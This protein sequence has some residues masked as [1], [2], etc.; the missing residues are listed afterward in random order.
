MRVIFQ[1]QDI[2]ELDENFAVVIHSNRRFGT[3][4][5]RFEYLIDQ[6]DAIDNHI[7]QVKITIKDPRSDEAYSV[8]STG[9]EMTAAQAVMDLLTANAKKKDNIRG[10]KKRVIK[11]R[12]SDASKRFNNEAVSLVRLGHMEAAEEILPKSSEFVLTPAAEIRAKRQGRSATVTTSLTRKESYLGKLPSPAKAAVDLISKSGIDPSQAVEMKIQSDETAILQGVISDAL[13]KKDEN[14]N[15]LA[16]RKE[17]VTQKKAQTVDDRDDDDVLP[18]L[19]RIPNRVLRIRERIRIPGRRLRKLTE[20]QVIFDVLDLEGAVVQRVAMMVKHQDL[21][22][23]YFLPRAAPS[24]SGYASSP[25]KN[26]LSIRQKD[27]LSRAVRLYRREI[28]SI[29]PLINEKYTLVTE[30]PLRRREGEIRYIDYTQNINPLIYRV[31]PVNFRG[32]ASPAMSSIV[33]Y[34]KN[35]VTQLP[36]VDKRNKFCVIH[37]RMGSNSVVVSVEVIPENAEFVLF[38]RRDLTAHQK[39]FEILKPRND[40]YYRVGEQIEIIDTHQLKKYHTYEYALRL[41]YDD[42]K[43]IL[44]SDRTIV[45]YVPVVRTVDFKLS[46]PKVRRGRTNPNVIFDITVDD[47]ASK[48]ETDLL[49]DSLEAD[50]VDGLAGS[51]ELEMFSDGAKDSVTFQVERFNLTTG[52]HETFKMMQ[53]GRF[54][55]RRRQSGGNVSPLEE[56]NRYVYVVSA[57]QLNARVGLNRKTTEVDERTGREYTVDNRKFLNPLTLDNGSLHA[58]SYIRRR[59]KRG[60]RVKVPSRIYAGNIFRRAPT[61]EV[62]HVAVDLSRVMPRIRQGDA[63]L[64]SRGQNLLS[65]LVRGDATKIDHFIILGT[66]LG[67][68]M[69]LTSVHPIPSGGGRYEFIER[70]FAQLPGVVTYSVVP[71]YLDFNRGPEFT[72]GSVVNRF[73]GRYRGWREKGAGK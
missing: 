28:P 63:T 42:G 51:E 52:D 22:R 61:G 17:L 71:V 65:W 14:R 9:E 20:F 53:K 37:A 44:G 24:I 49:M 66:K 10:R 55:D 8:F 32:R 31:V 56:G 68:K 1:G 33:I 13:I 11:T 45:E 41:I 73:L 67:E 54:N 64:M 5:Y 46:T 48:T 29:T 69:P 35:L 26:I 16:L 62:R 27:N 18:L 72:L 25:G 59:K 70:K 30:I 40:P 4:L 39:D 58:K 43:E 15:R 2:I 57:Y 50:N 3:T 38:L 23:Q 36:E 34:S 19:E 7:T 6:L 21:V 47:S 12:M 60:G